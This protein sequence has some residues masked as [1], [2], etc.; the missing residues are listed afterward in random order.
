M[1]NKNGFIF[2][3]IK[4]SLKY[5]IIFYI[6]RISKGLFFRFMI[7]IETYYIFWY[8]NKNLS[9]CVCVYLCTYVY[10]YILIKNL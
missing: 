3:E 10:I 8:V 1:Y 9:V 4:W 5:W 2:W 7:E 6:D